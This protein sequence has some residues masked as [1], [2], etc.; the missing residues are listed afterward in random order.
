[1]RSKSQGQGRSRRGSTIVLVAVSSAAL[2]GVGALAVDTG[3][4]FKVRADGQRAADA[5]ALAGAAEFLKT[6]AVSAIQPAADMA[7]EFAGRNYMGG[8]NIDVG[9]V[10]PIVH[11]PNGVHTVESNEAVVDVVP[12]LFRV[13]V[14]VR[15]SDSGLLFGNL[16]GLGNTA[17]ATYAAAEAVDAGGSGC[18]MPFALPD[19][20]GD[21]NDDA[22]GNRLEDEDEE[23]NWDPGTDS[24]AP[25]D[26]DVVNP[27]QTGYGSDYR[28]GMGD[29]PVDDDF[30]RQV[31]LKPQS[32]HDAQ[33]P[34]NFNLWG[35]DGDNNGSPGIAARIRG[36]DPRTVELGV[37]NAYHVI[38]GNRVGPVAGAVRDRIALDPNA[39]WNESTHAVDMS[40]AADW[41]N[42]ERVV[43]V[44][45]YTP[46]QI[47][48]H[49]N[50][51]LVF[52]NI[53]LFFLEGLADGSGPHDNVVGRFLYYASGGPGGGTT[54]PLVKRVRLVE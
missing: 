53:G 3:M 23:W 29:L 45:L 46:E 39:V 49:G 20:W 41:R 10:Q 48:G 50:D 4:M 33:G 1:M 36:C 2:L 26:P 24:Y 42:S 37:Q 52:N 18:V 6:D 32:P 40:N 15:R 43:K 17:I 5:A 8:R 47:G 34:G 25:F 28:N 16:F 14:T 9:G 30:G 7:L 19:M 27:N 44:A 31:V 13:R 22:N 12:S 11:G 51:G 21:N 54:G 38:P 35:F